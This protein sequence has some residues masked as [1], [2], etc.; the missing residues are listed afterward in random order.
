MDQ[1]HIPMMLE[2]LK[3]LQEYIEA[4][5]DRRTK[6]AQEPRY[7]SSNI[8]ELAKS[9]ASAQGEFPR[10]PYNRTTSTWNDE[11]SDLDITLHLIRPILSKNELAL[12]Q[13]CEDTK[14]EGTI[15]HTMLL[16][17][18]DQWIESRIRVIPH[19][20]DIKTFDSLMADHKK[21]QIFSLLALT[22]EGD[23]KDDHGELAM[24]EI[25]DEIASGK[26]P[27]VKQPKEAYTALT[28]EEIDELDI[29]L[30]GFPDLTQEILAKYKLRSLADMPRSKFRHCI[31]TVRKFK[32]YRN[33]KKPSR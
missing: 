18:S 6:L 25:H 15:L 28:Q 9:L 26:Q 19:R 7:R 22:V 2:D 10:I 30:D 11:Y 3:K 31:E 16:H 14:E 12:T 21:Q 4:E 1:T 8:N 13:W 33:E 29:E 23:I 27:I 17:S 32:L 5:V 20:S 24:H